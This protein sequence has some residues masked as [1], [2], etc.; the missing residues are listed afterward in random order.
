LVPRRHERRM[1]ARFFQSLRRLGTDGAD[2]K[3]G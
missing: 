1:Q 2:L 3:R